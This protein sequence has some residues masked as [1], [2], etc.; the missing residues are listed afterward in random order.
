M[1]GMF[2]ACTP[3]VSMSQLVFALGREVD[4]P[5]VDR[6]KL[7]GSYAMALNWAA[8]DSLSGNDSV[9]SI[10]T[11]VKDDLGLSLEPSTEPVE[12]LIVDQIEHPLSN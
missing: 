7:T 9:R 10:F 5:V 2:I 12:A 4:R 11:T 8:A 1:K 6:T 3:T